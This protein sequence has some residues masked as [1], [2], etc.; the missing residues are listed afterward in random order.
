MN[1]VPPRND[2]LPERSHNLKL[3]DETKFQVEFHD[4][5]V[6]RIPRRGRLQTK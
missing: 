5:C 1:V 3:E 6:H 2:R 4:L